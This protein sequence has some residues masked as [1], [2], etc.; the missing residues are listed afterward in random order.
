MRLIDIPFPFG[1]AE[2]WFCEPAGRCTFHHRSWFCHPINLRLFV[3]CALE[4]FACRQFPSTRPDQLWI[5]PFAGFLAI[6]L[7]AFREE[8]AWVRAIGALAG[9]VHPDPDVT[10]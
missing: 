2:F 6:V 10:R 1:C 9:A 7:I 5:V 3:G 4:M 8:Y